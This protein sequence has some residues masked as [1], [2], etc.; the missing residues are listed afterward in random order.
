MKTY[1]ILTVDDERNFRSGMRRLFHVMRDEDTTFTVLEASGGE[2]AME[3]LTAENV[4][5]V[6]MDYQMPGGNGIEWLQ[7]MLEVKNHVAIIMVTGHGNEQ[8]AVEAMKMGAVDYL[9]KGAIT[10]ETLLRTVMNAVQKMRMKLAISETTGET[11]CGG[12]AD[13]FAAAM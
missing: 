2:K 7:R 1:T 9:A 10:P 3:I 5:C 6:L 12:A 13:S 11:H 8:V 4:D